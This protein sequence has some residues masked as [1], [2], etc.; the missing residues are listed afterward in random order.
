MNFAKIAMLCGTSLLPVP[1]AAQSADAPIVAKR[2]YQVPSPNG[3][4]RRRLL[5]AA[6]RHSQEPGDARLP[7]GG[8]RLCR[9]AACPA[10]AARRRNSMTRPFRT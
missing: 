3:E 6:R 2:A 1:V 5:L 7:R 4:R 8:E 10:Q 9:R